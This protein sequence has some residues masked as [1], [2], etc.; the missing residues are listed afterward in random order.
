[1]NTEANNWYKIWEPSERVTTSVTVHPLFIL[2]EKN[3]DLDQFT[4][5]TLERKDQDTGNLNR[6]FVIK[7]KAAV[8]P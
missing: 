3:L 1:M 2:L 8:L 7:N 6:K 4:V 5:P